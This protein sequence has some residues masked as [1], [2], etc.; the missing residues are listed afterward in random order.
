MDVDTYIQNKT[1][2]E[3][4]SSDGAS[5]RIKTLIDETVVDVE[6]SLRDFDGSYDHRLVLCSEAILERS[7]V[8]RNKAVV[9][10]K[11][12]YDNRTV[13]CKLCV[14]DRVQGARHC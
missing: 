3:D 12:V 7:L 6:T 13:D 9:L 11:I 8:R 10:L 2:P 4:R 14:Y 5:W 1:P